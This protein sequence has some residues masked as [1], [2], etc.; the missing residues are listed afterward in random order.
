VIFFAQLL[1]KR[2]LYLLRDFYEDEDEDGACPSNEGLFLLFDL[3]NLADID[4]RITSHT[5]I[6]S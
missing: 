2:H 6:K 1:A 5:R 4:F 3:K